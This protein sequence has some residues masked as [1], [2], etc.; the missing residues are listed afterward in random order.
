[1]TT[2]PTFNS[3]RSGSVEPAAGKTNDLATRV[4]RNGFVYETKFKR[5]E[6][7]AAV[8]AK[9][10]RVLNEEREEGKLFFPPELVPVASHPIVAAR[11]EAVVDEVLLQRLHVYLD[12]TAELEQMSI[13][14]VTQRISR[15]KVGFAVPAPMVED[16]YK[17]CTDEAWHAQFSD[18]LQRQLVA[19]TGVEPTVPTEPQFF[20]RLRAMEAEAPGEIAGLPSIFFA[21][22][23]ETLISS[24]LSDIPRDERVVTAVRELVDDHAEDEGRHHAFFSKF[25]GCVWPQL[26]A[27]QRRLVGPF[28]PRLVLAFLEPDYEALASILG[29]SGLSEEHVRQVVEEAHPRDQVVRD[30]RRTS[31]ATLR[32]FHDYDVL[33]DAGTGEA[34]FAAGLAE[35]A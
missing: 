20:R 14:P 22:V 25:F 32:L 9:P 12:F 34:F 10:R 6:S 24:I 15:R 3:E 23:S 5:W 17:I 18:D 16:A 4:D 7:R 26:S 29:R 8:R 1:L 11:G 27:R 31:R 28:L 21:I 19:A 30:I 35:G 13:N 2:P 33:E